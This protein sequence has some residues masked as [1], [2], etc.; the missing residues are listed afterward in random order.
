MHHETLIHSFN[1]LSFNNDSI[2]RSRKYTSTRI[3][4]IKNP[5]SL[6]ISSIIMIAF[7]KQE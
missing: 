7:K 6:L 5:H 4:D 3:R 2:Y 1:L